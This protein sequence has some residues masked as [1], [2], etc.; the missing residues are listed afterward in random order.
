M[1]FTLIDGITQ[2]KSLEDLPELIKNFGE[3]DN[4]H[5]SI[6][7]KGDAPAGHYMVKSYIFIDNMDRAE[8]FF[9]FRLDGPSTDK[10]T[11]K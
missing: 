11:F 4:K 10:H 9:I 6:V 1:P 7:P 3:I 2:V 5:L 8:D